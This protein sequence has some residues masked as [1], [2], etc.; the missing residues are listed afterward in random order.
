MKRF[1][2][3]QGFNCRI[4]RQKV[5]LI[6]SFLLCPVLGM[7]AK[8]FSQS[9]INL[10]VQNVTLDVVFQALSKQ[11]DYEFLYNHTIAKQKGNITVDVKNKDLGEFLNDLLL[12]IGMEY[13]LDEKVIIIREKQD[14][15]QVNT[16]TIQG[17]VKDLNGIPLP[18]VTV[19]IKGTTLGTV[20]NVD[21]AFSIELPSRDDIVLHFSFIGMK[22]VEV[23]YAGQKDI[24]VTMH[25]ESQTLDDVVVTGYQVID[26]RK[27]TSAISTVKAEDLDKMG[28][29][30]VDQMLEG[31]APGLMIVNVSAQP[32]A[33]S[34]MR[35]RAGGT[36]TGTREPLWVIDGVVYE[37]PVPLSAADINSLDQVNLIGNAISGL[38]PQDIAQIDILKD[39][40]A[41]AIYGT[42]AA[43]GVIVITTKRGKS[44][45]LSLNYAG[46][47]SIVD[48]PRYS[49]MNLMNS[50]ERIDVSREI[51]KR[52]LHYPD[53]LKSYVGYEGALKKFYDREYNYAQFQQEVARL[54][55]MN[56]DWFGELYRVS[57]KHSHGVNLSGGSDKMRV[58]AGLSYDDQQGSE[59]H[60]GLTRV[61]GRVNTDFNLRENVL[62]S[63]GLSGSSQ[64]AVYN[65]S[66]Y[67]V[68][69]EASSMSRAV[70]ITDENGN[71]IYRDM[72]YYSNGIT[73]PLKYNIL[74]ELSNSRR[75]V[76]NKDLNMRASVDWEI[77]KGLKVRSQF[78]YRNTTNIDE[79]WMTDKTKTAR[80]ARTYA[81]IEDKDDDKILQY[82]MLPFGGL[83]KAGTTSSE[84][85]T[86]TTQINYSKSLAEVHHFNLN[87]GHE[88]TSTTYEGASGWEAPGYNHEQGRSFI[89]LPGLYVPGY[90]AEKLTYAYLNMINWLSDKSNTNNL[91]ASHDIYPTI[92]DSKSN[93]ISFF[94]IINYQYSDRYILNFNLRSDGSNRFGQY[95]RYKFRP[96]WSASLRWNIHSEEFMEKWTN[97]FLD[98]LAFRI[99]YGFRG[100]VPNA[101][102]YM[103]IKNYGQTHAG[104]SPEF[105]S[106]LSDFPNAN[107]KWERTKTLNT[108]LNYSVFGGRISGALDYAYSK[109]LDLLLT[110]PV[111]LVNGKSSQ[112]YNG[113]TKEDHTIEWNILGQVIKHPK[114][115]WNINFNLSRVTEKII[116]GFDD[117]ITENSVKDFL[118]GTIYRKGFPLDG[119][120]SYRFNGLN[121]NG[122]PTFVNFIESAQYNQGYGNDV[123]LREL[124]KA[125]VYEGNRLPKIYGGFGTEFKYA[126]LTLSASFAYKV[127]QKVRLLELYPGGTQ[128]MPMPENNMSA[129]FV[130]RWRQPGDELNT[131]IPALSNAALSNNSMYALL[132][133]TYI[134]P[135]QSTLWW[136]YDQSD[137]R[138]AKGSYIRWQNLS[139]YYDLPDKNLKRLGI[140]NVRIGFQ[141]QNLCVFTFDKK[142]KGMD[143]EQIR[144]I[145]L[146]VLPS[147]NCSLNFSF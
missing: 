74:E 104:V 57:I 30:T 34:K 86:L 79:E 19:Q 112:L 60:S 71:L 143:P 37:D 133:N 12:S 66:A 11:L 111:S 28:A 61:G 15:P 10:K 102:P 42:R 22:N 44:G 124:E 46:T 1:K 134:L 56:T 24:I 119:F 13:T 81:F 90:T 107:L 2:M 142:L 31:K 36:F 41:T 38:N 115:R 116:E 129:E 99:S 51:V 45:S 147:Y 123:I 25:E 27:L 62:I 16:V 96:A 50:R 63:V 58:Y 49:D 128:N 18:G 92:T 109:S 68:F 93:T 105:V 141:A 144:Y 80:I 117:N 139:L 53:E 55:T 88:V 87:L 98:E 146:P 29:L 132:A 5:F 91:L 125:L 131:S 103:I 23:K 67:S 64:K 135:W 140:S 85:Y 137:V 7:Y 108:G 94:C 89:K 76:R 14:I 20:T 40:S 35:V 101:S 118:N 32:G 48:R 145:G 78:S 69:N 82:S 83:Y 95:E 75:T 77:I 84:A 4:F 70:P 100:T 54:E 113:G 17:Y 52:N 97:T 6:V 39:A 73:I 126:N 59:I 72:E 3:N 114:F 122:E 33:A 26:K 136:A 121:S 110:R 127:G 9:K 43:N 21:G 47:V 130:N 8:T 65:H 106:E 120:Y 138:T